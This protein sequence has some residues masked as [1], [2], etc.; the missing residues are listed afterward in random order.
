MINPDPR[1]V[2]PPRPRARARAARLAV[3]ALA[4]VG[5]SGCLKVPGADAEPPE[6]A[7][8]T[9][10]EGPIEV[11]RGHTPASLY[12]PGEVRSFEIYREGKL[13]GTS[14]GR[15]EGPVEGAPDHHRYST[16][17]E[18]F[19]P[20][21]TPAQRDERAIRASGEIIVDARGDLVRGFER[22][23]AA[24]LQFTR[25]GD[26]L[27]FS[28]GRAREE[29]TYRDGTAFMSY[30]TFL[31]EELMLGLRTLR[32]GEL[33]WRQISLSRVAPNEWSAQVMI[34][35]RETPTAA[36]I[37]TNLGE[38]IE[39]KDG[40]IQ[41][42]EIDAER[43][44]VKVAAG[45]HAAASWPAWTIAAPPQLRYAPPPGAR[46]AIRP[47][48]LPGRPG[49]PKLFG[50]VLIPERA[51]ANEPGPAALF[52]SSNG[53]Q[54]RYGFAGPPP[55]DLGS[56]ELTDALADAGFV[57]LRFDER[58]HGESEDGELSYLAQLEDARRALRTLLV[59]D[60]VDPDRVAVIGHGDGGWRALALAR[61]GRKLKALALLSSP[62]RP[63]E[64]ILRHQAA[65][66]IDRLPP[67]MRQQAQE[68][69]DRVI[70]ALKTGRSVPPR[71]LEQAAWIREALRVRPEELIAGI[72]P[73]CALWISQGD[74]DFE[75]DPQRDPA[76][77]L[78]HV[79]RGRKK[80]T[81]K[82]Y[83]TLDH[84]YMPEDQLSSPERY[85]VTGRHV[86]ASFMD[87]L[88]EWLAGAL[89]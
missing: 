1:R 10:P 38:R 23:P 60:E 73:G 6:R 83:P 34:P 82:R 13:V 79:R 85:L 36:V 67:E 17:V 84:L 65:S 56:H 75:V 47:V 48:E 15:Y 51:T 21:T 11:W 53:R 50:E 64:E 29:L 45:D 66:M 8:A 57:V 31:H 43:V 14:H 44:E 49:E 16:R 81:F 27:V 19:P 41:R 89:R 39:W 71:L 80:A 25:E 61:E 77:L 2:S 37:H 40:R 32:E 20:D 4:L 5:V 33:T 42:V 68:E 26:A 7:S 35:D 58:G 9:T 18:L 22:S 54:D 30:W 12:K 87:E 74:K 70:A 24:E 86:D 46:F 88:A 76:A 55:V 28:S 63:Y 59:Q 72:E 3:V 78:R 52:I 69:H 62:G